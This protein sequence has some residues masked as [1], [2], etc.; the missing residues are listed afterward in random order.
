MKT[1]LFLVLVLALVGQVNEAAAGLALTCSTNDCFVEACKDV[2]D[3]LPGLNS[4][5]IDDLSPKEQELLRQ[6]TAMG[7]IRIYENP[8]SVVYE[9]DLELK[10]DE[11]FEAYYNSN[12]VKNNNGARMMPPISL[13]VVSD[14]KSGE[15][16]RVEVQ[17]FR[18]CKPGTEVCAVH[19]TNTLTVKRRNPILVPCPRLYYGDIMWVGESKTSGWGWSLLQSAVL[20]VKELDTGVKGSYPN[21]TITLIDEPYRLA[22]A[23]TLAQY[24]WVNIGRIQ[25]LIK[26]LEAKREGREYPKEVDDLLNG[27]FYRLHSYEEK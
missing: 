5:D 11:G 7:H 12:P 9:Q 15:H 14:I 23:G 20:L 13:A 18:E 6:V 25:F 16:V 3:P 2:P 1:S 21:G 8:D 27:I 24:Y 10:I 26:G 19:K 4:D 17:T 22:V